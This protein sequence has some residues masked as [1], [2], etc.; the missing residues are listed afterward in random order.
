MFFFCGVVIRPVVVSSIL[1][2]SR[3]PFFIDVDI[4]ERK[5]YFSV[6]KN[7]VG[8]PRKKIGQ[9]REVT[10]SFCITRETEHS[11]NE[12]V[13]EIHYESRSAFL[14]DFVTAIMTKD[15]N[16]ISRFVGKVVEKATKQALMN[17]GQSK[18]LKRL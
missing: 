13:R 3:S 15:E 17:F 7:K 16:E 14:R 4:K 9:H 11:L 5:S 10:C 8:R 12:F 18:L 1:G 2:H 6:M